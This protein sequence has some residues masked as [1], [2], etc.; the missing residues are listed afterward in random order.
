MELRITRLVNTVRSLDLHKEL[1]Q[2]KNIVGLEESRPVNLCHT[3]SNCNRLVK[4][5]GNCFQNLLKFFP[6]IFIILELL[7]KSYWHDLLNLAF[8]NLLKIF[9]RL[10]LLETFIWFL[11]FSNWLSTSYRLDDLPSRLN[12]IWFENLPL[13]RLICWLNLFYSGRKLLTLIKDCKLVLKV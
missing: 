7:Q 2:H 4:L 8:S 10:L 13:L 12:F 1:Q 6:F 3:K 9:F 5:T 11:E